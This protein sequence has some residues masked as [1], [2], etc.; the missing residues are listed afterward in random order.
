MSLKIGNWGAAMLRSPIDPME[1]KAIS[2]PDARV[3]LLLP[4]PGSKLPMIK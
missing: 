3:M 2:C 1:I 4:I